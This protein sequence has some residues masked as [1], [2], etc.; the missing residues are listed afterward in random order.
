[1]GK[2]RL[3]GRPSLRS[4]Q[5]WE[6]KRKNTQPHGNVLSSLRDSVPVLLGVPRTCV[7]GY[8]LP[9]L[10]GLKRG[11]TFF[12]RRAGMPWMVPEKSRWRRTCL[13]HQPKDRPLC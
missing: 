1:M 6:S 7:L 11:F 8:Y 12:N 2:V 3:A 9:P 10:R 5:G 13:P 4:L